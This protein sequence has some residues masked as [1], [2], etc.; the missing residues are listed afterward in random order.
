MAQ[1]PGNHVNSAE[2]RQDEIIRLMTPHR[3]LQVAQE[4]YETAW[5]LKLAGVKRQHP[6][7]PDHE[8]F[9]KV[10]RVFLTGYAGA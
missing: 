5:N 8:I 6:E 9:A 2:R 1:N 4:L 3:R 10:R 7:W